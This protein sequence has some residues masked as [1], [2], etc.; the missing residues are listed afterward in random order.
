MRSTSFKRGLLGCTL[1]IVATPAFAQSTSTQ[2]F[3]EI[4]VTAKKGDADVGGVVLPATSKAKVGLDA[5]FIQHETPGQTINDTINMLPGVSFQNNDPYGSTGG[6][7]SIR[8]FDASRVSEMWDGFPLN[9]TGNYAIYSNQ[10][11]DPE[12]IGQVTVSLGSTDVDSPSA[13]ATGSTINY[14]TR[15]PSE[16]FHINVAGSAGDY[17]FMRVFGVVDTGVF[18]KFGTRAFISASKSTN[19]VVFTDAGKVDKTQI[20]AKIYQPIGNNGDFI[21]IA[22]HYNRNINN[23]FGSVPLSNSGA[24]VGTGSG[25]RFP[26]TKDERFYEVGNCVSSAG[27]A[28]GLSAYDYRYNPSKTANLRLNSRFTLSDKL[29]LTV[30]AAYAYTL[31]NGGGTATAQEGSATIGGQSVAG[32][33]GSTPYFGGVDLNGD[34]D[35]N[36]AVLVSAPSTTQT[37]RYLL[38]LGLRYDFN[39]SQTVRVGYSL[40]YGRHRQTGELTTINGYGLATTPFPSADPLVD[41]TG[42]ALQKRDRFSK[43]LLN[44][45]F[46]EYRGRFLD[47]KLTVTA[48]VRVPFFKRDLTN[49]CFTTSAT[50]AVVCSGQNAATDAIIAAAYPNYQAPQNRT[51]NYSRVLPSAGLLYQLAAPLSVFAN[52]SKG[53]QVPGTDNLYNSFYYAAGTTGAEAA[54]PETTDNFDLGL[55]FGQGRLQAQV[56]GWYTVFHDRLASSY[57]LDTNTTIYRNLGTVHKYGV[58]GSISYRPVD[59]LTLYAFGS[60]LKSKILDDV[61]ATATTTYLTAGKREAGAPTYTFG[62]RAEA[63]AGPVRIGIE[64]KRTGE[65]YVNDQNLPVVISG[66]QVYGAKAPAYTLVNLD[67]RVSL[68]PLGLND[69]TFLQLNVTN[70]FDKLYVGGFSGT[71]AT[72]SLTYAQIGAPRAV[73]ATVSMGF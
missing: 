39:D 43:A 49:Y 70:L 46:G 5:T 48:G 52:Y 50:G 2:D 7:L 26:Q 28:C 21:S 9:D 73:S 47:S 57:D 72:N 64:A 12:L 65:R 54:K 62:G 10:Q 27:V 16:D 23:F 4:V 30:D 59:Q 34:G 61:Q 44:Q 35:T 56:S 20:N 14:T 3:D 42:T 38:N 17:D 13:S 37:N 6:T 40:D 1:C 55:R 18:T 45:G 32:Y 69:Q 24:S 71:S 11:L 25:N 8:G 51:F 53:M 63:N 68:K 33:V 36:D 15:N 19:D 31:A 22:G 58:D 29:T 41:A 67:A 66:V 60:Y